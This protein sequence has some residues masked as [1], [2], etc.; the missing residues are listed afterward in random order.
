M[1][2]LKLGFRGEYR[3]ILRNKDESIKR[4]VGPFPNLITNV[5]LDQMFLG[6]WLSCIMVGTGSSTPAV[7]QTAL[8]DEITASKDF[9]SIVYYDRDATSN[10]AWVQDKVTAR[11]NIGWAVGNLSEV[12]VGWYTGSWTS[13]ATKKPVGV[14]TSVFSRA[15]ILDEFGDPIT[16]TVVE[17]DILDVEYTLTLFV[18]TSLREKT[19]SIGGVSRSIAARPISIATNNSWRIFTI[20]STTTAPFSLP[21]QKIHMEGYR[22]PVVDETHYSELLPVNGTSA[23]PGG[24]DSPSSISLIKDTNYRQDGIYTW[25]TGVGNVSNGIGWAFL[26]TGNQN[27]FHKYGVTTTYMFKI[28]PPIPKTAS[29]NLDLRYRISV[30]R[31]T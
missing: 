10:P 26:T 15:L 13:S 11:F 4:I 28:D 16:I 25:N 7:T 1:S 22:S 5:G 29:N 18:D 31:H 14:D 17:D 30:A 24:Y 6:D 8:D 9:R 3:L 12:G 27:N 23:T 20:R 19:L 2:S 21:G